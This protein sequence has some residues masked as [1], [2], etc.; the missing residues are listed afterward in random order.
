MQTAEQRQT[1]QVID[2]HV[3]FD[4]A[5]EH[6]YPH[7]IKT[8][9]TVCDTHTHTRTH[10]HAHTHT[11]S[12]SYL[13]LLF[14]LC[15]C[16]YSP[17]GPHQGWLHMVCFPLSHKQVKQ[18]S[19]ASGRN[20]TPSGTILPMRWND[21]ERRLNVVEILRKYRRHFTLLNAL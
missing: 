14:M 13:T 8:L 15:Y 17:G 2:D 12:V 20:L 19:A 16:S 11:S 9:Y 1:F 18:G 10:T 6:N 7:T 4:E 21:R 3:H 5:N